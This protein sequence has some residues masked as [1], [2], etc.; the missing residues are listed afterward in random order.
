MVAEGALG[1]IRVVQAEY[2]QDWLT[3]ALEAA[4]PGQGGQKQWD[5]VGSRD[6]HVW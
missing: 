4:A 2:A 5:G 3:A 1:D 6:R